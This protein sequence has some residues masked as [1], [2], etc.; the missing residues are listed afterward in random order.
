MIKNLELVCSVVQAQDKIAVKLLTGV[1]VIWWLD[2]D[3]RIQFY[4]N[5]YGLKQEA[6]FSY[7]VS[8]FIRLF[9]RR[10]LVSPRADNPRKR[11]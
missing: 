8:L 2:W 11:E 6:T 9:T 7:Q 1:A 3:W 10:Q 4:N 5:L